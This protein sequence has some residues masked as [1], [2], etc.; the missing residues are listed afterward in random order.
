MRLIAISGVVTLATLYAGYV[1]IDQG[2][3]SVQTMI[4]TTLVILEL[5]KV[6]IIRSPYK[7][8]FFSNPWIYCAI[9]VS[10][11][12]Q[13]F[14]IYYTF[15]QKV[16]GTVSLGMDEWLLIGG[17]ASAVWFFGLLSNKVTLVFFPDHF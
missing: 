13:I 12:L 7:L 2:K 14:V 10:F 17:I 6:Q 3:G 5:V 8:K 9:A 11:G 16:F 15:I 4:F 1:V